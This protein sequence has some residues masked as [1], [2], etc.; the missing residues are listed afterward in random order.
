MLYQPFYARHLP[1]ARYGGRAYFVTKAVKGAYLNH[2]LEQE[3]IRLRQEKIRLDILSRDKSVSTE[4]LE[5]ELRAYNLSRRKL[6]AL[7]DN[8][9][10]IAKESPIV[11]TK[12][13]VW[14]VISQ[15]LALLQG[16]S[17]WTYAFCLMKNHYHWVFELYEKDEKENFLELP[18]FLRQIH[19]KWG[20]AINKIDKERDELYGKMKLLTLLFGMRSIK[21]RQ[22][23]T[24]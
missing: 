12:P 6:S 1:H 16:R 14:K 18:K 8:L 3:K 9:L 5:S 4:E 19:S 2:E 15:S 10:D 24:P 20:L 23:H 11:L 21:K 17:I 22:L 13:E 7:G